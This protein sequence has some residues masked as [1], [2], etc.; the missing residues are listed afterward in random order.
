M[1]LIDS[2]SHDS[3]IW[4]QENLEPEYEKRNH[5]NNSY[6]LRAVESYDKNTVALDHIYKEWPILSISKRY[7]LVRPTRC[8]DNVSM[9]S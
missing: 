6:N 2:S 4:L 3:K 1:V 7:E 5:W 9:K 8:C